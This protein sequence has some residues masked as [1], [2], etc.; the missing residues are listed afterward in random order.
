M[1]MRATTPAPLL[2]MIWA[3]AQRG[4]LGKGGTMA[5]HVP[6]DMA[7]FKAATMGCPVVMGRRTW[8]S[9][10]PAFR[11]LPGRESIVITR[12]R[13]FWADGATILTTLDD[14][15]TEA[16]H[17]AATMAPDNPIAW[18]IGGAQIYWAAKPFADFL[19]VTD[20]DLDVPE[21]DAFSPGPHNVAEP[22]EDFSPWPAPGDWQVAKDGT[23]YRFS[24]LV[25]DGLSEEDR[26]RIGHHL[27]AIDFFATHHEHL[28]ADGAQPNSGE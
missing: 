23:R 18:V 25:R 2:G 9:L 28:S 22:G 7:A 21:A 24:L 19:M 14:A 17:R 6:E 3:Q 15:L 1:S 16:R 8:E 26:E 4:A 5:W 27:S 10:P 13:L 11:P 12:N 20:I